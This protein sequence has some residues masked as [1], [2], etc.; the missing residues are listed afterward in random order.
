MARLRFK[1]TPKGYQALGFHRSPE[2]PVLRPDARHV[3]LATLQ[4][5]YHGASVIVRIVF[6]EDEYVQKMRLRE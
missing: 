6:M 5:E 1:G 4:A 2:D 3:E